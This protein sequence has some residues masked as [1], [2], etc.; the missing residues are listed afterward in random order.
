MCVQLC[1]RCSNKGKLDVRVKIR[2][3]ILKGQL[4]LLNSSSLFNGQGY[5]VRVRDL[6]IQLLHAFYLWVVQEAEQKDV[7]LPLYWLL[8]RD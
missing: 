2:A 8:F 5:E 7:K 3:E 4:E 1:L 6:A